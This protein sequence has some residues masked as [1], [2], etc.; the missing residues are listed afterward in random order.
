MDL[1]YVMLSFLE[2]CGSSQDGGSVPMVCVVMWMGRIRY[3]PCFWRQISV[4]GQ[5]MGMT[6][7]SSVGWDGDGLPMLGTD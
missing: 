1:C 2:L 3:G 5:R 6:G 4:Q 7:C